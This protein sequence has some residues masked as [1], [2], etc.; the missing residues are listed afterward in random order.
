MLG[1]EVG[2]RGYYENYTKDGKPTGGCAEGL[3]LEIEWQD[4]PLRAPDGRASP[5]GAFV[6]DVIGAALQRIE[7]YQEAA[8]GQFSCTENAEA[9]E[10]LKLALARLGD[11]TKRRVAAGTEGTYEGK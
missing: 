5:N 1:K 2:M 6:E 7:F 3:G 11:R 8:E 4:G 9:I 10:H